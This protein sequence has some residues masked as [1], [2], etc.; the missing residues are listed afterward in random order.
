[1]VL[2]R[3]RVYPTSEGASIIDMLFAS[4]AQCW[5]KPDLQ[6]AAICCSMVIQARRRPSLSSGARPEDVEESDQEEYSAW[7][8]SCP[9]PRPAKD[10]GGP[11]DKFIKIRISSGLTRVTSKPVR[12]PQG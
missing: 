7:V 5:P 4:A 8:K 6:F 12:N 11:D 9:K 2:S 10:T 1:V 3:M